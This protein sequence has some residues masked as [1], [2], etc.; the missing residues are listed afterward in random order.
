[1]FAGKQ[2]EQDVTDEE[3]SACLAPAF[4]FLLHLPVC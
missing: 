1:M 2:D 3:L 4:P